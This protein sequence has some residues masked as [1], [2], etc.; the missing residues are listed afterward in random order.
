MTHHTPTGLPHL[1]VLIIG[2]AAALAA[3]FALACGT[4]LILG[5]AIAVAD[6]RDRRDSPPVRRREHRNTLRG[7]RGNR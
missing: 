1:D 2:V 5:R 6:H 3:W 4:A 7:S